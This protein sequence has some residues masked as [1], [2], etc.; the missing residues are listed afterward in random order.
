ML[1][2]GFYKIVLQTENEGELLTLV[3]FNS[4]HDIFRAHFPENPITP[5]VCIIQILK[6]IICQKLNKSLIL[7]QI[8]NI[9]FLNIINPVKTP[10][11]HIMIIYAQVDGKVK[12]NVTVA[13]SEITYTKLSGFF[14][15]L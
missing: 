13:D 1:L 10:E 4:Q 15:E 6:N 9:K 8:T 2:D 12:V 7:S 3:R 14:T 11:V 5:G